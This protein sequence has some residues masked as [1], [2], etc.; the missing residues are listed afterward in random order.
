MAKRPREESRSIE[1][2]REKQRAWAMVAKDS[3]CW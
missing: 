2:G 3:H 1:Q